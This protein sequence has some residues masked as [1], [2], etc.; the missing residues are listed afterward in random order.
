MSLRVAEEVRHRQVLQILRQPELLCPGKMLRVSLRRRAMEARFRP[1]FL[2]L[3]TVA[4][5]HH[6]QALLCQK[7]MKQQFLHP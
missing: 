6:Q 4:G 1:L 5:T 7:K 2:R 3:R